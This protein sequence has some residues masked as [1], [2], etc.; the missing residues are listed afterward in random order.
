[1]SD[2]SQDLIPRIHNKLETQNSLNSNGS[3]CNS[4]NGGDSCKSKGNNEEEI[5]D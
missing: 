5:E 2:L 3:Q 1:M 4:N